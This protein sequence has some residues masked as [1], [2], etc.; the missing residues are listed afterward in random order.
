[1]RRTSTASIL[2]RSITTTITAGGE[3][4]YNFNPHVSAY[5]RAAWS[6]YSGQTRQI[7]TLNS[8]TD[9][10]VPIDASFGDTDSHE[11]NL[12]ARYTFAAGEKWRPFVG[13]A[14]GATRMSET[15]AMVGDTRVEIGKADTSFMQRLETG[16]QYSP[17]GNFDLRLT[18]AAN[19]TDGGKSFGR[20]ES[21]VV[22][23]RQLE[24]LVCMPTGVT[25]PRSAPSG[26]S[27]C[28]WGLTHY[29]LKPMRAWLPSQKGLVLLAPQRHSR[30]DSMRATTR[31]VPLMISMLPRTCSGPSVSGIDGQ[32]AIAHRQHVGLAGGRLAARGEVH[33]VMR[34]IAERLV[35]RRATTAQREAMADRR[36][37]IE[38]DVGANG[39]RASFAHGDEIHRRRRFVGL[40]VLALVAN[41]A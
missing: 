36:R 8:P 37:A 31:P 22:R 24:R 19:H 2:T 27:K 1:M 17:K 25:P 12:G 6:Q 20:P 28:Q 35:L 3:F 39:V 29:D 14:L 40:P 33:L 21:R 41:G 23:A 34:A 15:Y 9:G 4:D 18:A 30:A 13:A 32:R 10:H 11:L 38:P 26:T 7:G 16:V 5:A